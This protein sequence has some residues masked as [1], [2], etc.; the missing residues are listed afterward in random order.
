LQNRTNISVIF[1]VNFGVENG[2]DLAYIN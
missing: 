2:A 1:E